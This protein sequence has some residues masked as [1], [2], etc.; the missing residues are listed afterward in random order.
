[1]FKYLRIKCS[2]FI[3]DRIEPQLS[4]AS[5]LNH[6]TYLMLNEHGKVHE[7]KNKSGQRRRNITSPSSHT[8]RR[9]Q[10]SL[11]KDSKGSDIIQL[12]SKTISFAGY[13][14]KE[15]NARPCTR[16]LRSAD[17]R[18]KTIHS[19]RDSSQQSKRR[20]IKSF[21]DIREETK[22]KIERGYQNLTNANRVWVTN[23]SQAYHRMFTKVYE[24][25]WRE[26]LGLTGMGEEEEET[27]NTLRVPEAGFSDR[28]KAEWCLRNGDKVVVEACTR[29]D[30]IRRQME[31]YAE[32]HGNKFRK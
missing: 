4:A 9:I 8:N 32:Q 7:S 31:N 12:N 17:E 10:S 20:V 2:S 13:D 21:K 23:S 5:P 11:D 16:M 15:G 30:E 22:E 25:E 26:Y 18:K 27:E 24:K 6:F 3:T 1:M 14:E 19:P 28:K 29:N